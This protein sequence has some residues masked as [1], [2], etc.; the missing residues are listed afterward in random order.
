MT[1]RVDSIKGNPCVVVIYLL[2][3]STRKAEGKLGSKS[4]SG[5]GLRDLGRGW[6]KLSTSMFP[7]LNIFVQIHEDSGLRQKYSDCFLI[8]GIKGLAG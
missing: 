8:S 1:L 2:P 5:A 4:Q 3:T 7:F 6:M